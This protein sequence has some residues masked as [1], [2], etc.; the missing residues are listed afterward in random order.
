MTKKVM[1]TAKAMLLTATL[2]I[3]GLTAVPQLAKATTITINCDGSN[4]LC[5]VVDTPDTTYYFFFGN[6]TSV[7]ISAD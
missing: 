4:N 1:N 6:W 7:I 3:T 2:L 5:A